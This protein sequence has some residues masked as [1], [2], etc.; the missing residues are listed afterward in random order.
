MVGPA[1]LNSYLKASLLGA[2][3]ESVPGGISRS[4]EGSPE[5]LGIVCGLYL[6]ASWSK[7]RV[8]FGSIV[9]RLGLSEKLSFAVRC[10]QC[11]GK[12]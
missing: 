9:G 8:V 7:L 5:P 11:S 3:L 4:V 10:P 2:V 12:I 6:D 1:S